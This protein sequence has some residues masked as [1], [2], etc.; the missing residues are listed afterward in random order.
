VCWIEMVNKIKII[1]TN[2]S[3]RKIFI[4]KTTRLMTN[5]VLRQLI[6]V[7]FENCCYFLL[8][9]LSIKCVWCFVFM[10]FFSLLQVWM[11]ILIDIYNWYGEIWKNKI[12]IKWRKYIREYWTDIKKNVLMLILQY[13][14]WIKP[15]ISTRLSQTY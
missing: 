10:F 14:F 2:S 8:V 9:N 13:F 15:E 11:Q 12:L 7:G 1:R 5:I 6:W 3:T 4:L